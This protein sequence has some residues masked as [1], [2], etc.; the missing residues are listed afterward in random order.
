[1]H[2]EIRSPTPGNKGRLAPA[3][4]TPPGLPPTATE[5]RLHTEAEGRASAATSGVCDR[6]NMQILHTVLDLQA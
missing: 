5:W 4:S 3:A 1:M 2:E 6:K